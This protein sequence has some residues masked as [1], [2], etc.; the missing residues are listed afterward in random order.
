MITVTKNGNL[1]IDGVKYVFFA[2]GSAV[3]A[4]SCDTCAFR[5]NAA[6]CEVVA[7]TPAERMRAGLSAR[8]GYF[9]LHVK[10]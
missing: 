3:N 4:R 5:A 8:D 2:T 1:K 7:C 6:A 9:K 10:P